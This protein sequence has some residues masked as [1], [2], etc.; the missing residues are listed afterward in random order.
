MKAK[1]KIQDIRKVGNNNSQIFLTRLCICF[2]L[3]FGGISAAS[4]AE[5][6][7]FKRFMFVHEWSGNIE[8][9]ADIDRIVNDSAYMN[10][11]AILMF[12]S[13]E[14]FE[15]VR[16]P[17]GKYL[18]GT[19]KKYG[20]SRASWNMLEYAIQKAHAKNIQL[21][22]IMPI[23]YVN[24]DDRA[25][26]RLFGH[27]YDII[28][29]DGSK[30]TCWG[31]PEC[32]RTDLAFSVI[33]N[34]EIGL[35]SFISKHYTY[36]D[37]I[38]IE[39][40][41]YPFIQSYST[42]MRNRIKAKYGY[43]PLTKPESE[44]KYVI[45]QE[46]TLVMNAFFTA[47]RKSINS[48]K[49]N[50]NL[51]LSANGLHYYSSSTGF[52]PKYMAQ[53][54]LLDWYVAQ[55]YRD[56][57]SNYTKDVQKLS[58]YITEIPVVSMAAIAYAK[59][60]NNPNPA[61]LDEMKV[62]C[63]YGS[64]AE[65][66]FTYNWRNFLIN[67]VTA[68]EGLHNIKPQCSSTTVSTPTLSPSSGAYS[69]SKTVTISTATTGATIHYTKDGTTP[70]ES[71]PTYSG[72]FIVSS[73][74]TLRTK[75]WKTGLLP[76]AEATAKYTILPAS[77]T[78]LAPNA[79]FETDSDADGT[80]DKWYMNEYGG[81]STKIKF[82]WATDYKYSGTHSAKI[83]STDT[84][85]K[86]RWW[87]DNRDIVV[88]PGKSYTVKGYIKM[89]GVSNGAQIRVAFL[90]SNVKFISYLST[91]KISGTNEWTLLQGSLIAPI[92]AVYARIEIRME[93]SGTAWYDYISFI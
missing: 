44:V 66:L 93:G 84:N 63:Q 74:L 89:N 37:G 52:D 45:N 78:N 22:V 36:L 13:S 85:A 18:D 21:H 12:V 35:L 73:N 43:D 61:F 3:L 69:T 81:D 7:P 20:D 76:S 41:E 38:H 4:A 51:L 56:N 33:F 14:Y 32:S 24:D 29:R 92:N 28:R 67:G 75:A 57:V 55:L 8:S 70:T 91:D 72:S 49:T 19:L 48:N 64:D 10:V 34:Y 79:G 83:T 82:I 54:Q 16:D 30:Y 6:L 59:I 31:T 71:S 77:T 62:T 60:N 88:S 87:T 47:L 39:E 9:K 5:P 80:P 58:T 17:N 46:Q 23:N 86:A 42:E 27:Q 68:K 2:M 90:D 40:P 25:E 50:P 1:G 15:A 26:R 11:D 53:N 65:G